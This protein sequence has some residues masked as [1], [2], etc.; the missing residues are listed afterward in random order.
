MDTVHQGDQD[1]IKGVYHINAVD[2]VTQYEIVLSCSRIS[3]QFL[4]PVLTEML[5]LKIRETERQRSDDL[6]SHSLLNN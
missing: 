5:A 1:G 3:E 2:E 4:I 6:K